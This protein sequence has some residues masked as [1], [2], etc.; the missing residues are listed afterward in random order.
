MSISEFFVETVTAL[1]DKISI[2]DYPKTVISILLLVLI[3]GIFSVFLIKKIRENE[4]VSKMT[5]NTRDHTGDNYFQGGVIG[6]NNVIFC[7][8]SK[9]EIP[10][11]QKPTI[12]KAVPE[13]PVVILL[14][15]PGKLNLENRGEET[16]Y[17]WGS[18]FG[19]CSSSF[20][21]FPL[22]ILTGTHHYFLTHK[23]EQRARQNIGQNGDK[24]LPFE[25]YLTDSS[26]KHFYTAKFNVFIEIKDG[27]ITFHTH[28]L[29]INEEKWSQP[30]AQSATSSP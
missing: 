15:A 29:D 4:S 9:S 6:N 13:I 10:G 5:Q 17:L 2:T 22:K 11:I 27:T 7:G 12:K 8:G 26:K 19:D 28:Q 30:D 14:P 18:K 25:T 1:F 23:L 21:R 16:I 24:L 20:S 3:I